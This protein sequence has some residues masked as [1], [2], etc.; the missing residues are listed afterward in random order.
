MYLWIDIYV[1]KPIHVFSLT[2]RAVYENQFRLER[3]DLIH[4]MQNYV[5][6][7]LDISKK[8]K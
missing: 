1:E 7:Y 2:K 8:K 6:T 3:L 5:I 4:K